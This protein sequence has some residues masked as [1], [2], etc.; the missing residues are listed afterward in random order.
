MAVKRQAPDVLAMILADSVLR[1]AVTG[2]WFIHGVYS[3][4]FADEFPATYPM[5]VVYTSITNGH[6]KTN[7]E[8]KLIDVDE[9]FDALGTKTITVDFADPLVVID[10][11]FPLGPIVFPTPGEYRIQLFGAGQ[12][13]RERRLYVVPRP[14]PP[15]S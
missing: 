12:P 8:L 11:V 9:E 14:T 6:G 10:V 13:L 2:K 7:L 5:I 3:S 1:D 4:I 15:T